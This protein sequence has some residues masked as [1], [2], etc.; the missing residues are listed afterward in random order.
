MWVDLHVHVILRVSIFLTFNINGIIHIP[1]WN[2]P[3]SFL[4]ISR[5]ELKL[6]EPGKTAWMCG[7]VKANHFFGFGRILDNTGYRLGT[8]NDVFW[9][10]RCAR[11]NRESSKSC[12]C[13]ENEWKWMRT[14]S[15]IYLSVSLFSCITQWSRSENNRN[16]NYNKL[17]NYNKIY[18]NDN[19]PIFVNWE[20][21]TGA[22]Y[23][24]SYTGRILHLCLHLKNTCPITDV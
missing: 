10:L 21:N 3:L 8:R 1:F 15:S 24:L 6:V 9:Y 17:I 23:I 20:I 16:W 22:C 13:F 12:L 5:W 14:K 11:G 18:N 19:Y 7:L 2:C 4:G